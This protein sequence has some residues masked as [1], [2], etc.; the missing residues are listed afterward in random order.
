[1]TYFRTVVSEQQSGRSRRVSNYDHVRSKTDTV[2]SSIPSVFHPLF[3][4]TPPLFF[5]FFSLLL[6]LDI[7]TLW[8]G[9]NNPCQ[10]INYLYSKGTTLAAAYPARKHASKTPSEPQTAFQTTSSRALGN[11]ISLLPSYSKVILQVPPLHVDYP[12]HEVM[13]G[14]WEYYNIQIWSISYT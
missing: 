2:S 9:R 12:E 7:I 1:M 6:L 4:F 3:Y 14:W 5:F 10:L 11:I 8:E 13:E